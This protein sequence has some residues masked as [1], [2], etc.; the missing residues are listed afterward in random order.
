[1]NPFII[2]DKNGIVTGQK[3]T[4]IEKVGIYVP[5]GTAAYPS[6]VLMDSVPAKIAGCEEIVMVTPP[7]KDG[8]ITPV[9][10]AAAKIAGVDVVI[11]NLGKL[12]AA[13]SAPF[14]FFTRSIKSSMISSTAA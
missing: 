14:H 9:I 1:M 6:T 7:K 3:I 2:N 10:L 13:S 12:S 8:K 5:G 4:P 11:G